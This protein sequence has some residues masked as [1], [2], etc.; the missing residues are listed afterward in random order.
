LNFGQPEAKKKRPHD[1]TIA[2]SAEHR[3]EIYLRDNLDKTFTLIALSGTTGIG[4]NKI[5]KQGPYTTKAQATAAQNAI[6]NELI[7]TGYVL[8]LNLHPLWELEAQAQANA[9]R[10]TKSKTKGNYR[11]S[12]KDVINDHNDLTE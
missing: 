6:V 9:V 4:S 10:S 5:I 8:D 2:I 7:R 11:F 1:I 3:V 12:P